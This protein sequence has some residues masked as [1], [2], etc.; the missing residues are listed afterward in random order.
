MHPMSA[1]VQA[2]HGIAVALAQLV[3][4]VL[5]GELVQLGEIGGG[6]QVGWEAGAQPVLDH[7]LG[8]EQPLV[9]LVVQHGLVPHY[10]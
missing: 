3:T 2:P 1:E 10:R 8:G 6:Q 9:V 5:G 4:D 7:E